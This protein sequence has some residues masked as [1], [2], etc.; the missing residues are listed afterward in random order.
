MMLTKSNSQHQPSKDQKPFAFTA[1]ASLKECTPMTLF[2]KNQTP[3]NSEP[4]EPE[5]LA[6]INELHHSA[7]QF[8]AVQDYEACTIQSIA[9]NKLQDEYEQKTGL[10]VQYDYKAEKFIRRR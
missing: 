8:R 4:E 9:R 10:K 3:K 2:G 6:A 7:K 1:T 5:D